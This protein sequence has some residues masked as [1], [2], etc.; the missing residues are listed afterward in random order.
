MKHRSILVLAVIALFGLA[1]W[2]GYG[3]LSSLTANNKA[4][5]RGQ[6]ETNANANGEIAVSKKPKNASNKQ[7]NANDNDQTT[8]IKANQDGQV[9]ANTG[10]KIDNDGEL[11]RACLAFNQKLDPKKNLSYSDYLE[12][13]PEAKV[14]IEVNDKSLCL[15][16]LKFSK[17][18]QVSILPGLESASGD[19][20][21]HRQTLNISFG[22]KPAHV[23]FVGN[24]VILP[25]IGAQGLGIE[26]TNINKLDVEI[27]RVGDRMLARRSVSSGE[28][29]N[30]GSYYYG[31]RE[32]G[33]EIREKIWTGSIDIKSQ[34]NTV[35]KTVFPLQKVLGELKPGAYVIEVM[36]PSKGDDDYRRARAWR[37]IIVT[38][39]AFTSYQSASGLDVTIRSIA[40]A[41]QQ[42]NVKI[43]LVANNNEILATQTSNSVGRVHFDA[44]ILAGTGAMAP[45]ML[46]AYSNNGDYAVL[47]LTRSPLDLSA[48]AIGGRKASKQI[49]PYLFTDRG[50]YRPGETVNFTA[51]IRDEHA[52]SVIG[53]SGAIIFAKPDGQVFRRIRFLENDI[54]KTAGA[55]IREFELPKSASRGRWFASLEIDGLGQ[56]GSTRF[57]VE[58]FVPQKLKVDIKT[59]NS[60][61]H[62]D[63]I[64]EIEVSAQFLYGAIGSGLATEAE[65]RIGVDPN[66]FTALKDYQF[67]LAEKDFEEE[68]IDLGGSTTDEKGIAQFEMG[69]DQIDIDTNKPLRAEVVVGVSE[70]GGRYVKNSSFIPVR[71]KDFYIGIKPRFEGRP[72]RGKP[73]KFN[74]KAV[75][76]QGKPIAMTGKWSLVEEDTNY[77]WYRRNGRWQYRVDVR[78]IPI[79]NGNFN[80]DI[81]NGA[82]IGRTLDWGQYRLIVSDEDGQSQSSY[83][84]WVGWGGGEQ[85]NAPD[86][87]KMGQL[88]N[89]D[90]SGL[91]VKKAKSGELVKLAI[92]APY[93]GIG[94]LVIADTKVRQIQTVKIPEGNSSLS[95]RM[96]DNVGAGVYALLSVY[97]PRD[98]SSRPVPR[99]A[100]GISYIEADVEN[101][102]LDVKINAPELIRPR[103]KINLEVAI[104]NI[105]QGERVFL[106]LAAID[107]GV[108]QI[109]KYKSPDPQAFYFD[110]KALSV[111]LRDDYARILNPNLGEPAIARTGGDGLGGE[112]LTKAPIK[113]VSLYSGLVNVK[114]G[115]AVIPLELPDFNGKLRL[116]AVAW[117]KSALGSDVKPMTV[118]D[119]VPL[120]VSL[121]RFLAPG[122][123]AVASLSLDNVEGRA[124]EYK[125]TL[126]T[127][128]VVKALS[129]SIA[130]NLKKAERK[131]AK[132]NFI[133]SETG[134]SKFDIKVKGPGGYNIK[135]EYE[136]QT[137]SAFM[138]INRMTTKQLQ[139]GE[140]MRY[141]LDLIK[142]FTPNG[143]DVTI[144]F[145][146]IPGL[147]PASYASAV[148]RYPYGCSE[149]TV[150]AA[151]PLLYSAD[152]GGVPGISMVKARQ[153]LQAAIDRLVIRQSADGSFGLWREGDGHAQ[154]W[155][156]VYVTDFLHR[157]KEKKYIVPEKALKRA[158]KALKHIA[159][160]PRY[161]ELNYNWNN[162]YETTT[163]REAK[164]A[165]AAAYAHY[166]LA[167]TGQGRLSE[168]RYFSDNQS[169]KMRNALSWGHLG[170]AL[171]LMGD[172]RRANKAFTTA[173][174]LIDKDIQ[175]DYYQ[176]PSRDS[177]GLMAL[178]S[179]V[180]QTDI[181]EPAMQAFQ[182]HLK[183]PNRLNT[184]AQGQVIMAIRALLKQSG[185][186]KIKA[187]GVKLQPVGSIKTAHLYG[188]D[189]AK[190][191]SFTNKSD[192]PIW[193]NVMVSG[194]PK[195]APMPINKGYK[196]SKSILT[197]SGKPA[198]L[199]DV[200]Q[201]ERFIVVVNFKPENKR[202][203]LTVLADLLPAGMEIEAILDV[204]EPGYSFIKDLTEFQTAEKRDDRLVAATE[205]YALRDYKIAYLVRAVTPGDFIWPGAVVEDM[206]RPQ[207]QGITK[208]KRVVISSD[209]KY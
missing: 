131:Q 184:Q 35:V 148:S 177:A 173:L 43:D 42:A 20:I 66:P 128:G 24:G 79:T 207:T 3:G 86:Q 67:G 132:L 202:A 39:L 127:N 1:W 61:I 133:T 156:G 34:P 193:H 138:P 64:R 137:R 120:L 157:A 76:W 123:K 176:S 188:A 140:T 18:Y 51:L 81:N 122:D 83:R 203:G 168:L 135:T 45:K 142:G 65:A 167:R 30:E 170:A 90:K 53:R 26:T 144:S 94:E 27:Y 68:L 174:E 143:T 14:G 165:E 146:P 189:L 48:F 204:D 183:A 57:S 88:N 10:W 13:E 117:S 186:V 21:V 109:T 98:A 175:E 103:N 95:V 93:A 5:G 17:D 11:S 71:T 7:E 32:V 163:K 52:N 147:D 113:V 92:N 185:E 70:P 118:R 141:N 28:V 82:N 84:F 181:S 152:I 41:K 36:R 85:T 6:L 136:I 199:A 69:I 153:E 78:D 49:D 99:R 44:E 110:K 126:A 111:T 59:D 154:A 101:K 182:K 54:S 112:G 114:G 23:S 198:S 169:G 158:D 190:T 121:P 62:G 149:Q 33:S 162:P 172:E 80:I 194:T 55:L 47:D 191:I 106:T 155:L 31:Y 22:D 74:I 37:W 46:M 171:K 178:V 197:L 102:K 77:N 105:P 130:L 50:V 12:I 180:N 75:D 19:K 187:N 29:T 179:E 115:K 201:G 166:V 195:T 124:G 209:H 63:E 119:K 9:F 100:V 58:D 196:V 164:K 38:D 96:P 129:N 206:Y 104:A 200:K 125:I 72:A 205:T 15:S 89:S 87:I 145:T 4:G 8:T 108:L 151:L 107:E 40:S 73:A 161:P 134:I 97:T 150:S 2:I 208:A 25:R 116:M 159:K 56:V 160:M 192:K 139:A 60:P 91:A 16:G